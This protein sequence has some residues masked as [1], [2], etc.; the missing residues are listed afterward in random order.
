MKEAEGNV[1]YVTRSPY[2]A[3]SARELYYGMNYE[4][5][6]Q[7]VSFYS[8]AEF[9]ESIRVPQ[10]REMT[11]REFAGWFARHRTATGIKDAHQFYEE[12]H[13]VITGASADN[14]WLS[15][16]EYLALG[17][18]QIHL[19]GGRARQ[20]VR[21]V[22]QV[23]GASA[24][25]RP[26]RQQRAQFRVSRTRQAGVGFRGG[27]RGARPH[28]RAVALGAAHANGSNA[29]HPVRRF[30]PNRASQLFSPGPG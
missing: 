11:F 20:G 13:G 21:P 3:D 25:R 23:P 7:D 18:R 16:E 27:G 26:P 14:A 2:L 19:R 15:K 17:V 5:D 28:Q 4:N 29:L 12:V 22:R 1:L 6:E 9:L 24:I 30:Q 8:F 10:S